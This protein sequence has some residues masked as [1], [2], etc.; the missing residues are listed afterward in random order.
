MLVLTCRVGGTLRVGDDICVTFP[1]EAL[2]LASDCDEFIHVGI[3]AF[4][5]I[6]IGYEE[7]NLSTQNRPGGKD[8][9]PTSHWH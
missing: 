7:K 3:H 5:P 6:R 8:T 2:A 1:G 9:I 4:E